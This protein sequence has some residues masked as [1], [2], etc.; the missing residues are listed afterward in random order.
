MWGRFLESVPAQKAPSDNLRGLARLRAAPLPS[1][2]TNAGPVPVGTNNTLEATSLGELHATTTVTSAATAFLRP[3]AKRRAAVEAATKPETL[4]DQCVKLKKEN[5]ALQRQVLLVGAEAEAT[6]TVVDILVEQSDNLR[7]E[8]ESIRIVSRATMKAADEL[9]DEYEGAAILFVTRSI[10]VKA[11]ASAIIAEKRAELERAMAAAAA[12][13]TVDSKG[14]AEQGVNNPEARSDATQRVTH[15]RPREEVID[16]SENPAGTGSVSDSLP[17]ASLES[18]PGKRNA[19]EEPPQ[20]LRDKCAVLR[21]RYDDD[22]EVETKAIG[23]SVKPASDGIASN[24]SCVA[25][26]E[27]N[28]NNTEA[29][30]GVP[31]ILRDICTLLS[32]NYQG[33]ADTE[34]NSNDRQIVGTMGQRTDSLYSCSGAVGD[35]DEEDEEEEGREGIRGRA[36]STFSAAHV[37]DDDEGDDEQDSENLRRQAMS[38]ASSAYSCFEEEVEQVWVSP[39]HITR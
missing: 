11:I 26:T 29:G 38:R 18:T 14:Q 25:T 16:S 8:R 39:D 7:L 2:D 4:E 5:L 9:K 28:E 33:D 37:V 32:A 36:D 31:Q 22:G 1:R 17:V 6:Q 10:V 34:T 35:G 3:V 23:S 30:D 20:N 24:Q 27:N 13:E 19:G 21:A 12:L 15:S